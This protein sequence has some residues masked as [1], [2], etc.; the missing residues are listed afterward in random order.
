MT[1]QERIIGCLRLD[2][3]A[4]EEVESDQNATGQAMLVVVLSA[5]SAALGAAAGGVRLLVVTLVAALVGWVVWA[6]LTFVI[7]TKLLPERDTHADLGQMLRVLGFASAPGLF[8]VLGIVPLLGW[9]VRLVVFVWQL[10]AFVVAVR[11]GLDYSSTGRA[12]LVCLVGWVVYMLIAA[13]F[14]TAYGG[15]GV[16]GGAL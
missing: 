11:Q 12:V 2:P 4:F 9:I 8:G 1:L 10:T 3:R 6:A 16:P 14:A 7:G 5:A 13:V 15:L